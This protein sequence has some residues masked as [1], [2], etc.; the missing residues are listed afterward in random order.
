MNHS[1]CDVTRS[2][3]SS[4]PA[5]C[6][7]VDWHATLVDNA[8][9]DGSVDILRAEFPHV[10]FL[11]NKERYG[12][13]ANQNQVIGPV[14]E[15]GTA[16][17]VLV[18]NNDTELAPGSVSALVKHADRIPT[19][20]AIS[21]RIVN[22]DGTWQ[23]SSFRLPSLPRAFLSEI[24]PRA[25]PLGCEQAETGR[26]WLG[27]ACL[28]I[29]ADA[30]RRVG[31]FDTRF[32]LFFEDID[33]ARRLWDSGWSSSLCPETTVMHH[34]HKTVD[35]EELRFAMACQLRRSCYLYIE[36]YYGTVAASVLA[37]VGR[38]AM[39]ARAAI[40][41]IGARLFQDEAAAGRAAL[42]RGLATYNPR[43]ALA[44]ELKD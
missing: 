15:S 9:D 27:G 13:G 33:L 43:R 20:G 35:K 24:Y 37:V 38:I 44:H 32:F 1:A 7:G 28:L 22:P 18:L 40:Q 16:R 42:L 31:L 25:A 19:V 23:P 30:L 21:P 36:K 10:T 12:F 5:A 41:A 3:L 8:S 2:C 26:L 39:L 17:Y 34:N 11:C 14:V 6:E 4:L 29:R